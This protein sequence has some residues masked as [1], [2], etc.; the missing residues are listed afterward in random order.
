MDDAIDLVSWLQDY[1][2]A[3]DEQV[4]QWRFTP[5]MSLGECLEAVDLGGEVRCVVLH[6]LTR[7]ALAIK[8]VIAC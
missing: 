4:D 5:R 3:T 6:A 7:A 8:C 1:A 2:N